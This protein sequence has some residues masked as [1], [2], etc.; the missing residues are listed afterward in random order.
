MCAAGDPDE[1][2]RTAA[3]R[4]VQSDVGRIVVVA[5]DATDRPIGIVTR[6]DLLKARSRGLEED[7]ERRR[8]LWP[9]TD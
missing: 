2:C 4:M 6:S 7:G 5:P 1:S 9:R 8:Y 3:E